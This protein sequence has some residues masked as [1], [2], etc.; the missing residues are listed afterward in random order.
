MQLE[1]AEGGRPAPPGNG[2]AGGFLRRNGQKLVAALLW[3]AL[4]AL[5][6]WYSRR[7]GL[8]ALEVVNELVALLRDSRGGPL[9]YVL[10]YLIRPL[11]LFSAALLTIAAGLLFGPLWGI[12]VVVVAANCSALIAYGVGRFFGRGLLERDDGNRL[13]RYTARLRDHPFETVLT[14]RFLFA[15]FDPVS[16]LSGFL[17]IDWRAF[18]IATALGSIPGT[19]AFVLFGASIEGDLIQGTPRL[20][21]QT[22]AASVAIFIVSLA[23][24]RLF[25][26]REARREE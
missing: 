7:S 21:L 18:L 19:I 25:R 26:R 13:A 23:L 22:L 5:Y 11:F 10:I 15:P 24:S 1:R 17:R 16:Y 2:G 9:L 12:L 6:L 20:D 8:G 4:V 3:I 14:L